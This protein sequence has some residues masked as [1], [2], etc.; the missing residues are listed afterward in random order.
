M[1]LIIFYI[2]YRDKVQHP[3]LSFPF[4]EFVTC[5]RKVPA[6][7]LNELRE[8]F[9]PTHAIYFLIKF[10]FLLS[11]LQVGKFILELRVYSPTPLPPTP[12][13]L[14]L[15]ET[16]FSPVAPEPKSTFLRFEE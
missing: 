2:I 16:K 1:I 12:F 9:S 14:K 8:A 7:F 6:F 13:S 15:G 5:G 11:L 10:L 3:L 4:Q